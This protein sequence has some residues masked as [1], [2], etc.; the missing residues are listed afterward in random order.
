MAD[1]FI[2][3]I[4]D[5]RGTRDAYA[6]PGGFTQKAAD[7]FAAK[8][9]WATTF[10]MRFRPPDEAPLTS[11]SLKAIQEAGEASMAQDDWLKD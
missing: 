8:Y 6:P 9:S 11:E 10:V 3:I 2:V 7:E 1:R 5:T 4:T